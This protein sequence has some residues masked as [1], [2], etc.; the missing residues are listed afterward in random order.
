MK[1][2]LDGQPDNTYRYK[3]V[4]KGEFVRLVRVLENKQEVSVVEI[5]QLEQ[6]DTKPSLYICNG[7]QADFQNVF[8]FDEEAPKKY[9]TH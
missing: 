7:V 3:L 2:I 9:K 4:Q 6:K 1:I 8:Y 5:A